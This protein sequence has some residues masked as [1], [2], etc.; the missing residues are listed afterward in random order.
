P[1][2]AMC[3]SNPSCVTT[4]DFDGDGI[5][6]GD[7]VIIAHTNPTDNDK[8]DLSDGV[9][10]CTGNFKNTGNTGTCPNATMCSANPSC[11]NTKDFD[12]DWIEDGDE[13]FIVGTDPTDND[14]DNDGL[15]DGVETCTGTYVNVANTG[16]CSTVASCSALPACVKRVDFDNDGLI[17][18][19]D[20]CPVG[21][22]SWTSNKITD[23]DA[24]GCRDVDEDDCVDQDKDNF[25]S[26]SFNKSG[27]TG[28]VIVT[29][30]NKKITL[31]A[32]DEYD[33]CPTIYNP[34]QNNVCNAVTEPC[35]P[36]APTISNFM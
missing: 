26:K 2:A 31:R 10:T 3:S 29:R 13:V 15:F 18:S 34:D 4:K 6:D 35:P 30:C 12:G 27:C 5:E 9:E 24:D 20:S 8:D 23:I 22:T 32:T 11:V 1:N 21:Q 28:Q 14:T 17:D 7:E 36:K 16:T 25:G 33:N 19:L